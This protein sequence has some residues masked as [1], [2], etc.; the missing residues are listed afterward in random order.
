MYADQ[1]IYS[2]S[3]SDAKGSAS[4][5]SP[6][7]SPTGELQ[8]FCERLTFALGPVGVGIVLDLLDAATFGPIGIVF[9][10]LVGGAAGWVLGAHEGFDKNLRIAFAI[11]A[12]AYMMMPFTE[13]IPAATALALLARFFVGPSRDADRQ[14]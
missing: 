7:S 8:G 9:G 1:P 2:Y 10:A 5:S 3:G 13:A 11:A 14:T 12:A 6:P 4:A